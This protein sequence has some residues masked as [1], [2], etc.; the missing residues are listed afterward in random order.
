MKILILASYAPSLVNFRG[1]LIETLIDMGHTVIAAAPDF[2]EPLHEDLR[3]IGAISHE[4]AVSRNGISVLGDIRYCL[5]IYRLI[6]EHQ[7][8]LLF[9]YT[10]KPNIW[11]AFAAAMAGIASISMVTG[12]GAAFTVSDAPQNAKKRLAFS[13]ARR[14]YRWSSSLNKCLIFQNP[15]DL[16]DFIDVGCLR[17]PSK[18]TLV[19]GSGVDLSHFSPAPS[20][21][22]PVFL[23]IARLLRNKGVLE[24]AA[25]AE[26][27]R[28]RHPDACFRLIGPLDPGID[29]IDS[30][31]LQ[32]WV[33][34]GTIDYAGAVEDVRPHLADAMV[35]VLPSY[36]EGTPR[37]VLEAMATGRAIITTD[38]PGCRETVQEGVNGFLVPVRD[39]V[40]LAAAMEKFIIEPELIDRMG[41]QSRRIVTEKYDVHKVNAVMIDAMGL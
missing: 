13:I 36:R 35:Y 20:V 9:S 23:M 5:N 17:D 29:G 28:V 3:S 14:L 41:T 39:S 18:A 31:D 21:R 32:A 19:H 24:Y 7:P 27:L 25:A 37:S 34:A 2:T 30:A 40:A 11:G 33:A 10:I 1:P 16:Q 15:D 12:L 38:A 4:I 22:K 6:H 8:D 26:I